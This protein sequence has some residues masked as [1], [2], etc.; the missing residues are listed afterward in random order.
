MIAGL[1]GSFGSGKTTVT[2]YLKSCRIPVIDADEIA[3]EVT[4]PGSPGME[5]VLKT[6]GNDYRRADGGLDRKKLALRV[7]SNPDDLKR[8]EDIV[9]PLVRERELA[10]LEKYKN[11]PL[12][13]LSAPLLLE[14]GLD[15]YVDK[16]LVVTISEEV[17]LSRLMKGH[18][19][20]RGEITERLNSQMPQE[21]KARRADFIIDNSGTTKETQKR[22]DAALKTLLE[23]KV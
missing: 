11:E 13:V 17:R 14:K 5:V 2:E 6:F 7:F 10:L 23:K 19:M 16:I 12:V 15:R 18:K 20:T 1:T 22:V 4:A 8:L 3:R 21:E 9:H